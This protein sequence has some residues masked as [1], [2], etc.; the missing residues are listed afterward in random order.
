MAEGGEPVGATEV[1]AWL[2]DAGPYLSSTGAVHLV[3]GC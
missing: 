2:G 1:L 3:M